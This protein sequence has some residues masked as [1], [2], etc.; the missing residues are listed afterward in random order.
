MVQNP[1][2]SDPGAVHFFGC[3]GT[4]HPYLP[5]RSLAAS[6]IPLAFGSDGPM[7]PGLNIMFAQIHQARPGKGITR[8]QAVV[9]YTRGSAFAEFAEEEKGS[10]IAGKVADLVVLSQDIFKVAPP[11]LPKTISVLTLVGGKIA[12][13]SGVMKLD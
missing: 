4:K 12:Y 9:A 5:L 6:G 11:E 8:E 2:H 3:F 7:N 1:T 10:L 13:E